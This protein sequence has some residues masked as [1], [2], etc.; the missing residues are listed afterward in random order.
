MTQPNIKRVAGLLLELDL[1]DQ[2]HFTNETDQ[3]ID[4][5]ETYALN[6]GGSGEV[7][8]DDDDRDELARVLWPE[9]EIDLHREAEEAGGDAILATED[10][11]EDV[12]AQIAEEEDC[13]AKYEK[14]AAKMDRLWGF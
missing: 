4:L 6:S 11:T 10:D 8:A 9:I 12:E 13:H 1:Y 3:A 5:V 7:L 2:E 14:W